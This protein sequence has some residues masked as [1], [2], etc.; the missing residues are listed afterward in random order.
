MPIQIN[1]YCH[2][3]SHLFIAQT[4]EHFWCHILTTSS[5]S[6]TTS[7]MNGTYRQ[8]LDSH[9][10]YWNRSTLM[11]DNSNEIEWNYFLKNDNLQ[12]YFFLPSRY[13]IIDNKHHNRS[14]SSTIMLSTSNDTDIQ[15]YE[16]HLNLLKFLN[17][18][19]HSLAIYM[20]RLSQC[21]QYNASY[22]D[23]IIF[24]KQ[25]L[26]LLT[27]TTFD[28]STI[29]NIPLVEIAIPPIIECKSGWKYT[30]NTDGRQSS[31]VNHSIVTKV[32]LVYLYGCC[33]C[34]YQSN[35]KYIN[36]IRQIRIYHQIESCFTYETRE[37]TRFIYF[38]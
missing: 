9:S 24:H 30:T 5:S 25:L 28:Y 10:K 22:T 1:Y 8:I 31:N 19:N 7:M 34:S 4:P 32:C 33:C 15:Q 29:T 6:S 21:H 2:I 16:Y 20:D 26:P 18:V 23:L 11:S 13:F 37:K 27:N 36:H 38:I 17:N 35:F 12:H 3:Y 14:S